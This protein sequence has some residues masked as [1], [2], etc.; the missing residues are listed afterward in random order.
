MLVGTARNCPFFSMRQLNQDQQRCEQSAVDEV[1]DVELQLSG[2]WQ[3]GQLCG[4]MAIV[5]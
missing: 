3:A 5:R 4:N 1:L 2:C